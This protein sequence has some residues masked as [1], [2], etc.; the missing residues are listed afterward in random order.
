MD[1]FIHLQTGLAIILSFVGVKMLIN[2]LYHV[3]TAA[4]LGF[5]VLVLALSIGLSLMQRGRGEE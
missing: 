2:D 3:P 1:L 5:I 4:S